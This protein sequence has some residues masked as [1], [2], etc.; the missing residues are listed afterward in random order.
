MYNSSVY[1][2]ITLQLSIL[3]NMTDARSDLHVNITLLVSENERFTKLI[4]DIIRNPPNI[5]VFWSDPEEDMKLLLD[6]L[7]EFSDY[8]AAGFGENQLAT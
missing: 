8:T 2:C 3:V 7:K 4:E 5:T 6:Q 1:I